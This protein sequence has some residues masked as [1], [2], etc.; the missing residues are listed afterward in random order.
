MAPCC[1]LM[2]IHQLLARIRS[3]P[4]RIPTPDTTGSGGVSGT[5]SSPQGFT[6]DSWR[7]RQPDHILTTARRAWSRGSREEL[8]DMKRPETDPTKL[9]S[10]SDAVLVQERV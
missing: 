8:E 3:S 6:S 4:N 10:L 2:L 9:I 7:P 5:R 1:R